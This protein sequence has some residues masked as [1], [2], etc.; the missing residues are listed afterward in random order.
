MVLDIGGEGVPH[1][2]GLTLVEVIIA[3]GLVFMALLALS[4]LA[5][6]S[7]KGGATGKHLT[8]ATS[9]A[10]DRIE[11]YKLNG[12]NTALAAKR[13]INEPY[14]SL[15]DFPHYHRVSILEPNTPVRGL[16]TIT[17]RVS[18]ADDRHGV[19]LSTILAE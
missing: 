18:W 10:Q 1:Q 6:V 9:L 8:I 11:T 15:P 13:E 4:G 3:M 14:E 7:L 12:Y 16:Q 2:Q 19:S 5:V 17:V